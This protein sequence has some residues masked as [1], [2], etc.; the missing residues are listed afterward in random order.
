MPGNKA[1]FRI[2]ALQARTIQV[3]GE[4]SGFRALRD[5]IPHVEKPYRVKTGKENRA[6]MGLAMGGLETL[7]TGISNSRTFGYPVVLSSGW[8]VGQITQK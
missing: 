2:Y 1:V 3:T 4:G 8:I 6:L 7:N 5:V